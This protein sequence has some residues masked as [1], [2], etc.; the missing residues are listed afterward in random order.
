MAGLLIAVIGCGLLVGTIAT[1][2]CR[3]RSCFLTNILAGCIG[4]GLVT[5]LAREMGVGYSSF[6]S[7]LEMCAILSMS[8]AI[9]AVL[10]TWMVREAARG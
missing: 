1:L 7:N 3:D 2:P 8:G 5:F 4:A 9:I 6:A 10:F